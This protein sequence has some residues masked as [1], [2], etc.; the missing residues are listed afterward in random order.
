MIRYE[1]YLVSKTERS[2]N[3][4]EGCDARRKAQYGPPAALCSATLQ[5][6]K[7]VPVPFGGG[8][9]QH[10]SRGQAPPKVQNAK[11]CTSHLAGA[12]LF[13]FCLGAFHRETGSID[14]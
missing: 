4:S 7:S 14:D 12:A 9:A 5:S 2:A 6:C 11:R 3:Q 13:S 10:G 8:N 1:K